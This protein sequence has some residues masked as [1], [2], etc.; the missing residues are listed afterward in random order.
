MERNIIFNF[1]ILL[2]ETVLLIFKKKYDCEKIIQKYKN[3]YIF[4]I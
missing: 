4:L 3:H 2:Y 1:Q